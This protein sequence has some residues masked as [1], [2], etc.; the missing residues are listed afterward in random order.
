M[1]YSDIEKPF[2]ILT[3]NENTRERTLESGS[4]EDA[5]INRLSNGDVTYDDL[6]ETFSASFK[7]KTSDEGFFHNTLIKSIFI[8]PNSRHVEYAVISLGDFDPLPNEQYEH[9]YNEKGSVANSAFNSAGEKYQL[10]V[11]ILRSTLL[12]NTVYPVYNHGTNV[13]H[14]T[15]AKGGT[16]FIRGTA[17]LSVSVFLKKAP[18][19]AAMCLKPICVTR[20]I[21][22]CLSASR[23]VSADA[24]PLNILNFLKGAIISRIWIT[25]TIK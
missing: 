17:V 7:R 6:K 1:K 19:C 13:V 12:T 22:I 10:S 24:V 4:L 23:L 16:V 18:I 8:K 9:I 25:F 3:H 14:H 21:R 11:D 15:P 20:I 2:C 5:L